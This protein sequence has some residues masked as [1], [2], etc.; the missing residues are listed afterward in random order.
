[1]NSI[2]SY[3]DDV[4]TLTGR[5]RRL[6]V[7]V[8]SMGTLLGVMD[9]LCIALLTKLVA[10]VSQ[11][12]SH[13]W[14]L[15]E[16][17]GGATI[18]LYQLGGGLIVLYLLRAVLGILFHYTIYQRTSVIEAD[19]RGQ[20]VSR[21]TLM[22]YEKRL[23][24]S[25]GGLIT[26]V[27][28]WTVSYV[29]AV[30]GPLLRFICDATVGA[31]ILVYFLLLHPVA[32]LA[33]LLAAVFLGV[34]YD[35]TLRRLATENA[36]KYRI[37]AEEITE[38]SQQA[39]AGYKEIRVLGLTDFFR[40][41]IHQRSVVMGRALAVSNTI[42]Q[43]PRLIIE[44]ILI[45]LG[46]SV[47][48][49]FGHSGHDIRQELPQF[50]MLTFVVLRIS[51]L[52]SIATAMTANLRLYSSVVHQLA[53]DY[54]DAQSADLVDLHTGHSANFIALEVSHLAFGYE[55]K[56]TSVIYDLNFKLD[57]GDALAIIG[58]SG[59]G[60]TTLV[61]LLLGILNPTSGAIS[62]TVHR[63][64]TEQ[65]QSNLIGVASYL[66]QNTFILNDTL[67]R[68][69]ALGVID[70]EID[71]ARVMEALSK[72]KLGHYATPAELDAMMGDCG[73]RMSGGQRQ[74]VTLAR[75]FY[76]GHKVMI[77][78]EATNAIDL[79]TEIEI[80][81]DLLALRPEIT[82]ITITHR[83]EIAKLFSKTLD[84]S[85]GLLS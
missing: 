23:K 57:Q 1:M 38:S 65:T 7:T 39:L 53:G 76:H 17:M 59:S 34:I 25:I 43:S 63:D 44:A 42:G 35:R 68:N 19:L 69:V 80:V 83:P 82:L 73:A 6:L 22:P 11:M 8:V 75:A 33:F 20:L 45:T 61:D 26:S 77:L 47:L 67:R 14:A 27:N 52:I 5:N 66:S 54:R 64:G 62:V 12:T 13:E 30:L 18:N 74:R 41:H 24:R 70:S 71:D 55:G 46:I 72:A 40:N 15:P 58:Q 50:A 81:Q 84:L 85:K 37:L 60:K 31:L 3:C 36:R 78:D 10:V 51:S 16:W 21:F 29:R 2:F 49:Y 32:V 4:Y 56:L 48:L 28:Q 79:V 9:L